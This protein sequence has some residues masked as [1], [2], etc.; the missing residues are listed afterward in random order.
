L[1]CYG[2]GGTIFQPDSVTHFNM[3]IK[4]TDSD[5]Q[6]PR[7]PDIKIGTEELRPV[8][9]L[10]QYQTPYQPQSVIS[11][12]KSKKLLWGIVVSVVLLFIGTGTL[13]AVFNRGKVYQNPT[14]SLETENV[15]APVVPA[16]PAGPEKSIAEITA[17]AKQGTVKILTE[18]KALWGLATA[19]SQ[20]TGIAVARNGNSILI[21]TNQHVVE[22]GIRYEAFSSEHQRYAGKVVAVPKADVD[23]ALMLIEDTTGKIAP[24]LPIGSYQ[25]VV[26]GSEVIVFGHPEGLEFSVTRG[27]VSALRDNLFIQTDA[28]INHGNSG[29]PL[30]SRT[31]QIIG[32]NTFIIRNGHAEGLGFAIRADYVLQKDK[33]QCFEDFTPLW[34]DL[35][36]RNP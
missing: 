36:K 18:T 2:I 29:G 8:P 19:Q 27:I 26:Q 10:P 24:S 22:N 13:L 30:I 1:G 25:S 21:L 12:S 6:I 5:L 15:N 20:G 28:A 9:L 35:L 17:L 23:L 3:T 7:R 4:I 34:N 31:G 16:T 11:N 14:T 32:I 33:W